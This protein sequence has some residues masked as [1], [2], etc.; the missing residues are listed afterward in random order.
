MMIEINDCHNKLKKQQI[1]TNTEFSGEDDLMDERRKIFGDQNSDDSQADRNSKDGE[2]S[3]DS[4]ERNIEDE[5]DEF[6]IVM[7]ASKE[8]KKQEEQVNK[9]GMKDKLSQTGWKIRHNFLKQTN[10]YLEDKDRIDVFGG[11][12]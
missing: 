4:V 8:R 2:A 10:N 7:A 9:P 5:E 1:I 11:A 12:D 3:E 6:M